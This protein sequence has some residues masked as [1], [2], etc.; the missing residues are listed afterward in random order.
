MANGRLISCDLSTQD[1]ALKS[2][3]SRLGSSGKWL[4]VFSVNGR[5]IYETVQEWESPTLPGYH[6]LK[7]VSN[8][9]FMAIVEGALHA[10]FTSTLRA[11]LGALALAPLG[12][13]LTRNA[14]T[15]LRPVV[16]SGLP[17]AGSSAGADAGGQGEDDIMMDIQGALEAA[18]AASTTHEDVDLSWPPVVDVPLI[19]GMASPGFGVTPPSFMDC[20]GW[21]THSHEE[22]AGSVGVTAFAVGPLSTVAAEEALLKE[23]NLGKID[24]Y[25]VVTCVGGDKEDSDLLVTPLAP[26]LSVSDFSLSDTSRKEAAAVPSLPDGGGPSVSGSLLVP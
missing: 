18:A 17:S 15:G 23:E 12:I 2:A 21:S 25:S 3:K 4:L 9:C 7:A 10:A 8:G 16:P 11:A 19:V 14:A 24:T 26:S 13:N 5:A 1:A 22:L 20:C 6:T